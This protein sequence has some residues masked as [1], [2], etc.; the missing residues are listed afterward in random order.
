M[1][2][3]AD[4][5]RATPEQRQAVLRA[6]RALLA[7]PPAPPEEAVPGDA[8]E[9]LGF[10]VAGERYA[11]ETR[12]VAQALVLPPLTPLPGVPA[13]VAGIAAFR[14]RV[15]AA[16]DL[17]LLLQV[18]LARLTEPSALVVLQGVGMEFGLL[19]DA[20]L[21]VERYA[22]TALSPGASGGAATRRGYLLG[23]APDRTALLDGARLLGDPALVV[24]AGA[25]NRMNEENYP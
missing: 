9:V 5:D 23:V 4:P 2:A 12:W 3:G 6:R 25:P 18:Q 11:V 7:R 10:E 8:L 15:V 1:S 13:H 19:A 16:L 24:G 22:R 17:R 20:V 14:G 21:G